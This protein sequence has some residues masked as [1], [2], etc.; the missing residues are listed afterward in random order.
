MVASFQ[1]RHPGI[2]LSLQIANSAVIEERI[3][4]NEIDLVL[5]DMTMP[6]MD[7]VKSFDDLRRLNPDVRVVLVSG[8]SKEDV[9]SRFAGKMPAG[10]I[11]KPYTLSRLRE[12]LAGLMS[13]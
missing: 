5:L 12:A 3:R 11:Q 7:G 6:C 1:R 4:G 8:Y 13:A 9:S 10:I 2:A